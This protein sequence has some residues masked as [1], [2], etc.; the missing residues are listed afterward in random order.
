MTT[1]AIQTV[2]PLDHNPAAVYLARLTSAHSRRTMQNALNQVADLLHSDL[3]NDP[4]RWQIVQWAQLRQHH[5]GAIRARLVELYAPATVNKM[6]AALRGVL[7]AA[8][9]LDLMSESD[10]RHTL[11]ALKSVRGE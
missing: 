2:E 6:Q 7:E 11:K 1:T 9:D 10:Y 4:R 3:P 8:Y 5:A